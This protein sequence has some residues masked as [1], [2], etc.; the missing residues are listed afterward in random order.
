M[1]KQLRGAVVLLNVLVGCEG[2]ARS[3]GSEALGVDAGPAATESPEA[4]AGWVPPPPPPTP[5][6]DAGVEECADVSV[7]AET[8]RL[9]LDIVWAIDSSGSMRNEAERVQAEMNRFAASIV[10]DG[11][12]PRVVVITQQGFV[13]VPDPLGSNPTQFLFVDQRVSSSAALRRLVSEAPRYLDFLRGGTVNFVAVTDDE[14][15]IEAAEFDRL[16]R[17][18]GIADYTLHAI[19]S[20]DVRGEACPGAARPGNVYADAASL[21]GGLFESICTDDWS[22][23]FD[24][25]KEGIVMTAPVPCAFVLPAPPEGE[26]LDYDRVNVELQ[27]SPGTDAAPLPR[28]GSS[29]ECGTTVGWSYDSTDA[30]TEIQLCPASCAAVTELP[31]ARVDITLGCSTLLL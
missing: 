21:T 24:R 16:I 26:V 15:S 9:P 28:V 3:T 11:Y 1:S 22:G 29:D 10:E 25:L 30:P 31:E 8:V 13:S 18:A 19:A 5:A 23:V 2:G 14:S 20:E 12:D 4:D 17:D 7:E 6:A 27:E